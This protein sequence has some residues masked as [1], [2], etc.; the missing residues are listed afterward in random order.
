MGVYVF[1]ASA[2]V[3][4][5]ITLDKTGNMVPKSIQ[6]YQIVKSRKVIDNKD[7]SLTIFDYSDT[8]QG[9]FFLNLVPADG[10]VST[11]KGVPSGRTLWRGRYVVT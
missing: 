1:Y 9:Q 2:S 10:L 8:L 11:S 4:S 7:E 6:Y 3:T 5:A